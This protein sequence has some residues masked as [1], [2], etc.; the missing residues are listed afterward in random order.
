MDADLEFSK[1]LKYV[2]IHLTFK[3]QMLPILVPET[4]VLNAYIRPEVALSTRT[5][6]VEH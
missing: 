6:L 3:L 1:L 5:S 2:L 4:V